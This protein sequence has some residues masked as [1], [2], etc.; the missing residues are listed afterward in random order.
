MLH[1]CGGVLYTIKKNRLYLVLGR[2][3]KYFFHFKGCPENNET[4]EQT[5]IREINEETM[6]IVKI[7]KILLNCSNVKSKKKI[8][9]LGLVKVNNDIVEQFNYLKYKFIDIMPHKYKEKDEI[10]LFPFNRILDYRLHILTLKPILFYYKI[11]EKIQ[12]NLIYKSYKFLHN[13]KHIFY[14]L[15]Y[16]SYA[17]AVKNQPIM[18]FN[19][20]I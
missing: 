12:N 14:N 7:K 17:S 5:A 19:K 10:K 4:F 1:S 16:D 11:L 20:N 8:Y 6:G 9:R 15:K 3:G 18:H 13:N 2:E